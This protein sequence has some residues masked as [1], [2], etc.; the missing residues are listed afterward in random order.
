MTEREREEELFKRAENRENLQKRYDI[1]RK[2]K[3]RK[4]AR[5]DVEEAKE[6]LSEDDA[7]SDDFDY[8]QMLDAKERSQDRRKNLDALKFDKKSSALSDLKARK[9]EREHKEQ[10]RKERKEKEE[11][12]K[13]SDK[14]RL[15]RIRKKRRDSSSSSSDCPGGRAR[16]RSSSGSSIGG[17]ARRSRSRSDSSSGSRSGS[18]LDTDRFGQRRK[19]QVPLVETQQDLEPVRLSRH[20]LERFV[21]L[22]F[23]K[24]LAVGCYVRIKIGTGNDGKPTYRCAKI[25]EVVE[26]N[27]VYQMGKTRTNTG[28]RVRH[29]KQ[30]RVYRLEFVSSQPFT[31]SEFMR[32]RMTCEEQSIGM[33]TRDFVQSKSSEIAKA[34][35]HEFSSADV[36]SIL[37]K[38]ERFA[39]FPVNYAMTKARLRKEKEIAAAE[40]DNEKVQEIEG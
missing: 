32:W 16:S 24:E 25:A 2:L 23:F 19:R 13:K 29:G 9:Q 31:P 1:K 3:Q 36:E 6:P 14:P 7:G 11:S 5:E 33:P 12:K 30:E 26:T 15:E 10:E 35:A 17:Q 40:N 4:A 34:L 39:K 8:A 21:H 22:P 38:K 37:K 18:D 20:K 27:K 28:I